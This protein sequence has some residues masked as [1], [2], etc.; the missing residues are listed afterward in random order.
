[1][2]SICSKNDAPDDVGKSPRPLVSPR[3]KVPQGLTSNMMTGA[4]DQ[5]RKASSSMADGAKASQEQMARVQAFAK[6]PQAAITAE[7][8]KILS[9]E[10]KTQLETIKKLAEDP[11]AMSQM[12]TALEALNDDDPKKEEGKLLLKKAKAF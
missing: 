3:L 8:M 5:F 10:Q 9:D 6:D 2:G 4:S 12:E 7:I 11:D 1:M